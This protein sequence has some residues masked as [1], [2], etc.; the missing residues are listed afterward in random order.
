MIEL[1]SSRRW[2]CALSAGCALALLVAPS[3]LSADLTCQLGILDLDANGGINPATGEVWAAGDTYHLAYVTTATR[4]A[5]STDIADYN[6]FVQADAESQTEVGGVDVNLVRGIY[7]GSIS[8]RALAST[9]EVDAVNNSPIT[10]PVFDIYHS[11]NPAASAT[12]SA[13]LALD[14]SDFWDLQFPGNSGSNSGNPLSN[15][16]GG[17]FNVW[18]G[19]SAAGLANSPLGQGSSSRRHW[20]GWRNWVGSFA[21]DSNGT[22]RQM[23]AISQ[24]LTIMLTPEP[25]KG[26]VIMISSVSGWLLF[27]LGI[28]Y[29]KGFATAPACGSRARAARSKAEKTL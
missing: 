26:T 5:T 24:E 9:T 10:G 25:S 15:L 16:S 23:V 19:T 14:A 7:G 2:A 4:D 27:I 17:N 29:W 12:G 3:Q 20:T 8:W 18:T 22:Q 1:T 6:A 13:F 21:N 11:L 28:L